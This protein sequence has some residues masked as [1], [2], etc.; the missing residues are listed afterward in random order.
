MFL[1]LGPGLS[2]DGH[3]LTAPTREQMFRDIFTTIAHHANFDENAK[4]EDSVNDLL[5]QGYSFVI[6]NA[7][8]TIES[9]TRG[10][11]P[12][13][14]R[15]LKKYFHLTS[16][17]KVRVGTTYP[18]TNREVKGPNSAFG[19]DKSDQAEIMVFGGIEN[20]PEGRVVRAPI[21]SSRI[22]KGMEAGLR[23]AIQ[24]PGSNKMIL[25]VGDDDFTPKEAAAVRKQFGCTARTGTTLYVKN[26]RNGHET[27]LGKVAGFYSTQPSSTAA[28][29][30]LATPPPRGL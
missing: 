27:S 8:G 29:S 22:A 15:Y 13:K 3:I 21:D 26:L 1:A 5:D 23:Y 18:K 11:K 20:P 4:W 6:M 28:S 7:D 25:A 19:K 10:D 17:T 16:E 14:S 24:R 12:L 2:D 30:G 9:W